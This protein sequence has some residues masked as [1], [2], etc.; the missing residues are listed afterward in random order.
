[1]V[2]RRIPDPRLADQQMNMLRHHDI[3][4]DDESVALTRLL[5]DREE[6]ITGGRIQQRQSSIA[7]ASD[8]V[9]VVRTISAMQTAGR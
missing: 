3:P 6:A 9:Q 4:D 1:M 8:E 7:R 5:E 2:R